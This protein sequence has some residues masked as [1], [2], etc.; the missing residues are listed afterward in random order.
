M[1]DELRIAEMYQRKVY[2]LWVE[3]KQW[4]E[5]VP[6]GWGGTQYID[7]RPGRYQAALSE[8]V[9]ILST[10]TE[11]LMPTKSPTLDFEPRNPYKGLQAFTSQDSSD[12]FG[13]ETLINELANALED[14]LVV[15][16]KQKHYER[17]LA[18]VGPSGSGKSSVV[19]AGLLPCL[20]NGGVLD[21][22][23]WVYLDRIL[24]GEHPVESHARTLWEKLSDKSLKAIREDLEDDSKDGLHLL[25][26]FIAKLQRTKVVLF[27]DQF[28]ELFTQTVSEEERRRFIDLYRSRHSDRS[29]CWA[30][31]A[32]TTC[33]NSE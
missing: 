9:R 21:S 16:Q 20:R 18:V 8:L 1:N 32:N 14:F 7:A 28:E 13:R 22:E 10:S 4:I 27:V 15:E 17:L 2:P 31:I 3:G 25:A 5:A 26:T 23:E 12:F 6:M 19:M 33:H 11:S 30:G 24:P 29:C